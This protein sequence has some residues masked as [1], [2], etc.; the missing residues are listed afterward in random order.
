[1]QDLLWSALYGA[2]GSALLNGSSY[3]KNTSKEQFDAVKL[4]KSVLLGMA[5]GIGANLMGLSSESFIATPLY[6][7][8]ALAIEN[9]IKAISRKKSKLRNAL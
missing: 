2:L 1:M 4:G 7:S 5:T 9:L 6:A 8:I 3:V